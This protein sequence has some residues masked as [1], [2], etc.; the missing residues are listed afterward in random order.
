MSGKK[1]L[2]QE[3]EQAQMKADVPEFGAGDTVTV[4]VKVKEGNR[5]RLQAFQGVVIAR[6]NRG[7]NSAFTVRKVSH[8]VGVER[9]FQLHSPIIDSIEVNRRGDV[10]RAKLYYLRERSGKSARIKEKIR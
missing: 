2:I 8:G 7:L 3:I 6:R 4:Q 9:V 10:R 1:P 5:E